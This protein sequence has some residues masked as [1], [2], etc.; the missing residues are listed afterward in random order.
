MVNVEESYQ[1]FIQYC[2]NT[3]TNTPRRP[4]PVQPAQKAPQPPTL[5]PLQQ[6]HSPAPSRPHSMPQGASH[7]KQCVT[8]SLPR[9]LPQQARPPVEAR[10]Q[11][12]PVP[13][14]VAPEYDPLLD[15]WLAAANRRR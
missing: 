11:P 2:N 15:S 5:P 6:A 10:P 12:A 3:T 4:A 7:K 9:R 8:L 13:P 14:P 1:K